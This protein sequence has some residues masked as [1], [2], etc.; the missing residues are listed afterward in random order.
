MGTPEFGRLWGMQGHLGLA[1]PEDGVRGSRSGKLHAS[2]PS[3]R[4][5]GLG[6]AEAGSLRKAVRGEGGG[7]RPGQSRVWV[8]EGVPR[9]A[10]F[11]SPERWK[12]DGVWA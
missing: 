12:G 8:W 9:K 7:P 2:C 1:I 5:R 10:E 11:R 3:R 4:D 6:R